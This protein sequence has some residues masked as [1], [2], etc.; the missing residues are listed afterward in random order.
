MTK[1]KMVVIYA[2]LVGIP[3]LALLAILRAGQH[4]TAPAAVGGAWNVTADLGVLE[5]KSCGDSLLRAKQ[6]LLTISQSGAGLAATVN[7]VPSATLPGTVRGNSVSI[8]SDQPPATAKGCGSPAV[9]HIA[10]TVTGR[11]PSRA[12]DGLVWFAGCADCDKIPFR[13]IPQPAATEGAR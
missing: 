4:L 10:A 6:P 13:A 3:L 9:I 5:G 7:I 8:G 2:C 11:G 1:R 12:L